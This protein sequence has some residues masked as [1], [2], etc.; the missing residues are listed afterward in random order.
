MPV[1]ITID[2]RDVSACTLLH[3]ELYNSA[4]THLQCF[5]NVF[6]IIQL[7]SYVNNLAT[8]KRL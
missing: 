7:L 8:I 2:R 6:A 4:D 5:S 3:R 1:I